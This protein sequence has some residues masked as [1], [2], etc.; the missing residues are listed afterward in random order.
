MQNCHLNIYDIQKLKSNVLYACLL[1][2]MI[3]VIVVECCDVKIVLSSMK[4]LIV[5]NQ[6]LKELFG[7][8]IQNLPDDVVKQCVKEG[9]RS[10]DKNIACIL[11]AQTEVSMMWSTK[12]IWI[13]KV[14]IPHKMHFSSRTDLS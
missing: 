3:S 9:S 11:S 10:P 12:P 1:L 4:R 2:G 13:H 5:D 14:K 6:T 8:K 7:V